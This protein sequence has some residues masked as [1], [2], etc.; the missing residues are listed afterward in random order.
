MKR[1]GSTARG[2]E[3]EVASN[4]KRKGGAWVVAIGREKAGG[5][6]RKGWRMGNS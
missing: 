4:N 3:G 2:M 1:E 6:K 5:S